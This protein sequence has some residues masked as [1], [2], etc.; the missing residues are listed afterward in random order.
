MKHLWLR[1]DS[2]ASP[3]HKADLLKAAEGHCD[4]V[5]T[6]P[7]DIPLASNMRIRTASTEGDAEIKLLSS[8]NP[9]ENVMSGE[10]AAEVVVKDASD[11]EKVLQLAESG[12][13]YLIVRCPNWKVIPLENL[14]AKAKQNATLLA[15]VSSLTEAKTALQ[16]LEL[17]VDGIVFSPK[18]TS[19]IEEMG[20]LLEELGEFVSLATAKVT[21]ARPIGLGARVCVDTCELMEA[22]EGMLVGSQSSGLFLVEAE[23]HRNPHV[24]PRPFRVNAGPVSSYVLTPGFKTRYLSELKAGDE[25]LIVNRSGRMRSGQVGRVKIERRPM[26]LIESDIDGRSL[27]IVVQNAETVRLV[28]SEASKSVSELKLGDDVLVRVEEGGRHFG[29][30]VRDEMVIER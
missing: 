12:V 9:I 23:V 13:H 3:S 15:D 30:L 24:E 20:R 29:T 1:L 27:S 4:A 5:I 2:K 10:F 21:S 22:G 28:S 11:E 8:N 19:E 17:G 25:V 26:M 14:I 18:V 16:T 7:E 6:A